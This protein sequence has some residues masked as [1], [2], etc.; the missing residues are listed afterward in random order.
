MNAQHS[1]NPYYSRTDTSHLNVSNQEW[2]KILPPNVY[3]IARN[4]GTEMAFT[5]KYWNADVK[6]TY[7]CAVCGNPLFRS[8]AKFAS[9]CGWP[10]FYEPLR[11]NSVR[12][13]SDSSYGMHRTEVLCGRCDSH[14]GHIFDDGPPPT[15]KRFCMN[16]AV[17]EFEPD[18]N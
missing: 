6:G 17:L 16:S 4:K 5:G 15:H 7:Y 11:P 12:Y 14:L 10:S 1:N 13:E 2:K 18:K 3:D 8:D 9:S